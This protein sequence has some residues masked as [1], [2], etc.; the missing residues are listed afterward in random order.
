LLTNGIIS[1]RRALVTGAS[2][3]IGE[4]VALALGAAGV[5]VAVTARRAERLSDLVRRI[6]DAGGQAVAFPADV[7]D[8]AA[9]TGVVEECVR[10]FGGLDVL[11]NSAGVMASGGIEEADVDDWRRVIDINLMAVLYTSKAAIVPMKAQGRG[12]IVI[13]SSTA[14]QRASSGRFGPYSTSKAALAVMTEGLRREVADYGIR[15]CNVAPGPTTSEV[16]KNIRDPRL[17]DMV[18]GHVASE[19]AMKPEDIAAAILFVVSLPW[20]AN[21]AELTISP[22][23]NPT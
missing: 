14:A 17:R 15:V 10:T 4:G 11:V 16:A 12:D 22:T 13:I 1:G 6:E 20:R 8:E 7:A 3:G 2:S 18:A 21:V 23:H 19:G 5:S 9:A